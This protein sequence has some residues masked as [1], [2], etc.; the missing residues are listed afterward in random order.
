[1][2]T[3]SLLS[4]INRP[5]TTGMAGGIGQKSTVSGQDL[6]TFSPGQ[7]L[8]AVV[9]AEN[10]VNQF[11]LEAGGS[12]FVVA[13]K[14]PL[15]PGQS[16][17]LQVLST[18]PKIELQITDD[19]VGRLLSRSLALAANSSQ[20]LSSFFTLLQQL[21]PSQLSNLSGASLQ[22]LQEFTL[23][24]QQSVPGPEASSAKQIGQSVSAND[25]GPKILQQIFAQLGRQLE[26]LLGEGKNQDALAAVKSALQDVALLF[27]NRGQVS[28][29]ALSQL[30]QVSLASQ[31]L[32][33]QI[34][35]L[36]QNSGMGQGAKEAALGEIL[37][38]LQIP[39][40]QAPAAANLTN[41]L[42]ALKAG[43]S[44][45]AFL[46]KGPESLLQLFSTNSLQGGWLS[47][48]QAETLFSSAGGAESKG[49]DLLLQ[50]VNRLGLNLESLL[51]AGNKEEAVKTV[52]FALMELVQNLTEQSKLSETG[53][54]ALDN[55]EFLQLTQ[56]QAGRQDT[57]VVPLPLPFLEQGYLVV[58][59][60]KGGADQGGGDREMPK[61]FSLFLKLSPLG[62][63]RVDFLASG[64]G[65]YIRFN[66]ESKEVSDFLAS[67]K[68]ELNMVMADSRVHG[69]SFTVNS[70]DPLAA[71]LKRSRAGAESFIDTKA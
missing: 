65:V 6:P 18:D 7:T 52:K 70:E 49:G 32:Y 61:H 63:L 38:N 11:T 41:A 37:Q 28:Q 19:T 14:A 46:L 15:S 51:A 1:M 21:A 48:S 8:R 2:N 54:H 43:I 29:A 17:N 9:V 24:Q 20:G 50:L 4:V 10:A 57:L 34:S 12:R 44:E 59:D 36:Q 13:S 62:N 64:D 42:N 71:V 16:L 45:L 60:Y 22:A 27:Q 33:E 67:F 23:L 3:L 53:K 47:Q 31:Q 55:L 26:N 56:L 35:S 39:A 25:F 68:D 40:E 66:S 30:Q 69:V 58:E 5:L